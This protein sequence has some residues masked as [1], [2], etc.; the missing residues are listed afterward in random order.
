MGVDDLTATDEGQ[1]FG[2][3]FEGTDTATDARFR[4][5]DRDLA[6]L[7]RGC[8]PRFEGERIHGATLGTQ[9]AGNAGLLIDADDEVGRIKTAGMLEHVIGFKE[10]TTAAATVA[11]TVDAFDPVGDPVHQA[12]FRAPV[13]DLLGLL[14][15]DG[16][17]HAVVNHVSCETA[18]MEADLG[19]MLAVR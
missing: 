12:L 2:G 15:V 9:S 13:K 3:A 17:G 1:R 18:E 16:T 8:G 11:D 6:L 4:V 14:H 10:D 19:G 5:Q 7:V